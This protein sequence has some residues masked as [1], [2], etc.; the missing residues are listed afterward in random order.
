LNVNDIRNVESE[1]G[2]IAT[3]LHKPEYSFHSEDLKANHF[4]DPQNAYI[5]YAICELAKKGIEKI[6]AYN[7]TNILN[8][9][10]ATKKQTETITIPALN[11]LIELSQLICRN[12]VEEYKLLVK[13]VLDKAFRRD[14]YKKLIECENLCFSDDVENV[15]G[16]IYRAVCTH[17]KKGQNEDNFIDFKFPTLN[18]YCKISRTDA[19]IFAAREK[20]G[21]SLMLLN[22]LVDLL[23]KGKSAIYIDTELDTPLFTMR[24]ISHLAQIEFSKIR[25]GTY[26]SSDEEKIKKAIEWIKSKNFTHKYLPIIDDDK[27]ISIVK[28]Y[29]YKYGVDAV[30]LDYLKGNGDFSMDAYKNSASLG[31]TTDILKNYIAGELKLFVLSAVQATSTGAIADSAKIIRNCSALIYLERKTQDTIEADG[32]NEYGNMQLSVKANRNGMIMGDEEY[33]SLTLDGNRCTFVESKQPERR[34]PY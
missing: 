20:R 8:A 4:S 28:Q 17:I 23:D 31:K 1:A 11:E 25:D 32:G 16:I 29:K 30:I 12:S 6:D 3:L 24:L 5:Y 2:I 26:N 14:T 33:I 34:E 22:C 27:I 19:I 9:R 21:K 13:N 7:I 15:Q 18:K 10:E